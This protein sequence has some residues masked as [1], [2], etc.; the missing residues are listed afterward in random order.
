[1]KFRRYNRIRTELEQCPYLIFSFP[2]C[3]RTWMKFLIGHYIEKHFNV[4]F[5]K[6]LHK[7]RPGIPSI[8]FRHDFMSMTGNIPWP[9]YFKVQEQNDFV[10]TKEYKNN[11][12]IYLYRN[13]LDVLFSYWP[14]LKSIPYKNF[15]PQDFRFIIDFA[16][17]KQWGL[18]IIIKFMNKMLDHNEKNNN[19]K[20]VITY[21][22]MKAN[23]KIWIKIIEFI[24]GEF[25]ETAFNYAK[26]QTIFSKMQ[27]K[28]SKD[29]PNE[30]KFY[31]KGG[32]N[33]INE[34]SKNEQNILQNWPGLKELN[35]RINEKET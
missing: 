8:S 21:E 20:L 24:F 19:K 31:R 33:Y 10:F 22:Q 29:V 25:N 4:P 2:R 12:I 34:L 1:M 32:S 3:G 30:I 11:H 13:P 7:P 26:E 17:S 35:I 27:Q 18:D 15:T 9:D 6:W 14:Y 28:N 5:S 23:D 16:Y